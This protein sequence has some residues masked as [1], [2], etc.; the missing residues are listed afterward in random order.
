MGVSLENW[1]KG[2]METKA[3]FTELLA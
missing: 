2:S 3:P 1:G